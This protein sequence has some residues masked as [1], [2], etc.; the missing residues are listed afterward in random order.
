[1]GAFGLSAED[2]RVARKDGAIAGVIALWDQS[3]YKQSV[4]R[5]YSG[6]L[7][8]AAPLLPRPGTELRSAY[9][10]LICIANDDAAIFRSLLEEV[11][12]LAAKRGF[13]YLLIGLDVRDPLLDIARAYSHVAYPSRLYLASWPN[14]GFFDESLDA[15]PVYVDI[16]TL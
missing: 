11:Y 14:G 3:A 4:I 5:G 8:A 9:A 15:R 16:A 10:S 2:I 7:R 12:N 6:W 1:M 13:A